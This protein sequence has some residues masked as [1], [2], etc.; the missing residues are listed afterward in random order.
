[1]LPMM[2]APL[3]GGELP[4]RRYA[5]A[6]PLPDESRVWQQ[7]V[8]AAVGYWHAWSEDTRISQDLR[9]VCAENAQ[10][11]TAAWRSFC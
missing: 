9:Q 5:P 2:Y 8:A 1:M 4:H 7:A 3:R 10:I 6:L 11:L